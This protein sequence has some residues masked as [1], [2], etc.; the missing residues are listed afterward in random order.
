MGKVSLCYTPDVLGTGEPRP[1][2]PGWFPSSPEALFGIDG[3]EDKSSTERWFGPPAVGRRWFGPLERQRA[4]AP[5]FLIAAMERDS[6]ISRT[7][8]QKHQ[9]GVLQEVGGDPDSFMEGG[10]SS[11]HLCRE[12]NSF[13]TT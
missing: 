2:Q 7:E 11:K 10:L 13:S 6:S 12:G 5:L 9:L 8:F 3:G 4:E 1:A